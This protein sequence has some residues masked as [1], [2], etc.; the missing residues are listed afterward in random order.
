MTAINNYLN[1]NIMQARFH[2]VPMIKAT[3]QHRKEYPDGNFIKDYEAALHHD[4]EKTRQD[5]E[6][7][8]VR[9]LLLINHS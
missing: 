4:L 5:Q 7:Q 8:A 9:Y 1:S 3:E 6:I 2:S